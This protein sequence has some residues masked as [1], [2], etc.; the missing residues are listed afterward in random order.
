MP[1]IKVQ[2][3]VI[4]A[5]GQGTR[6]L[7]AT[8]AIPKEMLPLVDKPMIE[9]AVDEAVASGITEIIVVIGSGKLQ[10]QEHLSRRYEGVR[11]A[12]PI[13]ERP[14]GLGHAVGC[15]AGHLADEPFA[16]L[17]PDEIFVD[18]RPCLQQL[19]D[20]FDRSHGGVL[21]V[22]PVPWTAVNR[23]GIVGGQEVTPGLLRLSELVE[24]PEPGAAPSDLA[25]VGRYVVHPDILTVLDQT[26]PGAKGEIQLTDALRVL[27]ATRPLFAQVFTGTRYDVG[28]KRDYLRANVE[29]GLQREEY[30]DDLVRA[31]RAGTRRSRAR[32]AGS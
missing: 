13:Q 5:A 31:V 6:M 27:M 12:F 1:G 28:N 4:P 20:V 26:P 30:R 22:Q 14:R 8:T 21:S 16:V 18:D 24:K 15:A 17:L 7:P 29:L 3:A 32:R 2:Q 10:I 23:Y 19:L 9:Y 11:F 25:I